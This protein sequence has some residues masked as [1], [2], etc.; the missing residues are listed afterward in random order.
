MRKVRQNVLIWITLV[1]LAS[2]AFLGYQIYSLIH[3]QTASSQTIYLNSSSLSSN[4][5]STQVIRTLN[6]TSFS[7]EYDVRLSVSKLGTYLIG[8]DPKGFS[9][10]Y[11]LI[12]K[13]DGNTTS[14]SLNNTKAQIVVTDHEFEFKM[15][16]SGVYENNQT[17]TPQVIA[18]ALGLYYQFLSPLNGIGKVS[19]SSIDHETNSSD[20]SSY[21]EDQYQ[22]VSNSSIDHETNSSDNSS[23]AEDQ[24]QSYTYYDWGNQINNVKVNYPTRGV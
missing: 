22:N 11:V 1:V 4:Q 24:Y 2:N 8:I 16:V 21:A 19:N 23:Y 7:Y 18:N 6:G 5:G 13:D 17:V 12:Y 9:S 20:N 10:L 15:F 14:L 3:P